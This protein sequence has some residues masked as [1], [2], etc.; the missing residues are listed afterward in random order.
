[1]PQWLRGPFCFGVAGWGLWGGAPSLFGGLPSYLAGVP[2]W[3]LGECTFLRR[4]WVMELGRCLNLL[5]LC[6]NI[7]GA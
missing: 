2:S 3:E 5:G 1:M 7:S 4:E 6:P